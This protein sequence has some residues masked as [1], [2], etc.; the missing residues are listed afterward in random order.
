MLVVEVKDFKEGEVVIEECVCSELGMI[1]FGEK[2]Y[3]V[4]EDVLVVLLCVFM[5]VVDLDVLY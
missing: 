4:V 1:K 2:F 5:V 3:C